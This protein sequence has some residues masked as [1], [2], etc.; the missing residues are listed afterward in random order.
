MV[1]FMF[2]VGLLDENGIIVDMLEVHDLN[3]KDLNLAKISWIPRLY[4]QSRMCLGQDQLDSPS[5][6]ANQNEYGPR[7]VGFLE[8]TSEAECFWAKISW[9][10]RLYEQN[11]MC[12]GQDQLCRPGDCITS[13]IMLEGWSGINLLKLTRN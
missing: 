3:V 7:S 5:L 11:R 12:L 2:V 4:E 8:P 9:I 1:L 10:P 13:V 6:R